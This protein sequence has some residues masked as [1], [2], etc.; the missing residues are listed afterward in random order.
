MNI[1][2]IGA[3]ENTLRRVTG[4]KPF[5]VI[6]GHMIKP[7][8]NLKEAVL[9][10]ANLHGADLREVN[11][12]GATLTGAD[13]GY[14]HISKA[15]LG[16]VQL[17]EANLKGAFLVGSQLGGARLKKADLSHA[18]LHGANLHNADLR[19]ANLERAE[20]QKADLRRAQLGDIRDAFVTGAKVVNGRGREIKLNDF[21]WHPSQRAKRDGRFDE[22]I[23]RDRSG[24]GPAAITRPAVN[25]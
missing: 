1:M 23:K 20:L 17:D 2:K 15:L 6:D 3:L 9:R 19:G 10:R 13:L 14:A 7:G 4:K 22:W 25:P 8:A 5:P 11:L 16:S 18:D 21:S 24:E 12:S